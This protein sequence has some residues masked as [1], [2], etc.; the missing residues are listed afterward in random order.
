MSDI[1]VIGLG[2]MGS[3][4]A[5][6]LLGAGHDVSVWNRNP[7]KTKPLTA[8]GAQASKTI[9]DA[10]VASRIILL[11]VNNYATTKSV[12]EQGNALPLLNGRI[13]VQLSS[14]TPREAT[15]GE[16]WFH[17]LG[18][19]YLDGAILGSPGDIGSEKGQILIAGKDATWSECRFLLEC[20]SGNL[21]HTGSK[22]DSAKILDQAWLS[23]RLGMHMGV[24]QG[25]LLCE[26]GGVAADVFGS[27]VAADERVRKL[28]NTIHNKTFTDPV[29]TVKVWQEALHHIQIQAQETGTSSEV[30]EF[31]ADKFQ[32]AIS[33][34]YAEEDLAALIKVFEK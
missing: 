27:T 33:A 15:S 25:L 1:T 31:I 21:Q 16:G 20:L 10:V 3:A 5:K 2:L 17:K 7:E 32:R 34:G 26:A 11:C 28:A 24:F 23:Q 4:L 19:G 22:I 6:A 12:F 18:A 8:K 30:L 9:A 29:N 14:G 13:V